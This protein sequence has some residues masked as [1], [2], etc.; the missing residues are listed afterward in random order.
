MGDHDPGSCH[1]PGQFPPCHPQLD[2]PAEKKPLISTSI[3]AIGSKSGHP[4][5]KDF[6][7]KNK[8]LVVLRRILK[9]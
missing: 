8:Y 1:A 9:L 5:T 3:K 2:A 7:E 4:I 6:F